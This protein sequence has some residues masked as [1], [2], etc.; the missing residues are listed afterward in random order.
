MAANEP[1]ETGFSKPGNTFLRSISTCNAL[2]LGLQP[3]PPRDGSAI[4]LSGHSGRSFSRQLPGHSPAADVDFLGEMHR[5][6]HLTRD[7][8]CSIASAVLVKASRRNRHVLD[9]CV[10]MHIARWISI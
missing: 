1:C 3:Y 4:L 5:I 8:G 10:I 9:K 6:R 2:L 7:I